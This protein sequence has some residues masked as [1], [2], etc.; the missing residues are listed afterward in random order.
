LVALHGHSWQLH[1]SLGWQHHSKTLPLVDCQT[2]L[3]VLHRAASQWQM[4]A[5]I[6][7]W[8]NVRL[9]AKHLLQSAQFLEAAP[10]SWTQRQHVSWPAR[11]H[12]HEHAFVNRQLDVDAG[13]CTCSS[14][15]S[16]IPLKS[17]IVGCIV[18]Q[19]LE[20]KSAFSIKR[21]RLSLLLTSQSG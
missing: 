11:Q 5:G 13:L 12:E 2:L 3:C 17:L 6:A 15:F 9:V 14:L 1:Q 18:N 8:C 16:F 20:Q 21:Q 4:N 10:D 19:T 7:A